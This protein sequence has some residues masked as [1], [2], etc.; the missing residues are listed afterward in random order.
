MHTLVRAAGRVTSQGCLG[1][2]VVT[3]GTL[4]LPPYFDPGLMLDL[5]AAERPAS[6]TGVPAMF[7]SMLDHPGFRPGRHAIGTAVATGGAVVPPALAGRAEAAFAAPVSIVFAQAEAF[8][9]IAQTLPRDTAGDRA[10]TLGQPLPQTEVKI[11]G[12]ARAD[13]RA[14]RDRRAVHPRLSR[15]DRVLRDP[16][17]TAAAI[18]ADGWLHTGDLASWPSAAA[19]RSPGGSRT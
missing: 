18:D 19:A 12:P 10:H 17:R 7:I 15:D 8:P 1:G 13:R 3:R 6:V 4:I 5:I 14:R 9:V 2:A 16:D 11:I